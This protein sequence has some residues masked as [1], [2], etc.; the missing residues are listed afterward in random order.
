MARIPF[1]ETENCEACGTCESL[2]PGIFKL[3]EELGYAEVINPHGGDEDC[4]QEAIESCPT[5][6]IRWVEA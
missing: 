1:I 4:I 2:C 5:G 3:N 6:C